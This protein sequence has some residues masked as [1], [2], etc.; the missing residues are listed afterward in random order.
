MHDCFVNLIGQNML[1]NWVLLTPS[2]R[3]ALYVV[4]LTYTQKRIHFLKTISV[5]MGNYMK[6]IKWACAVFDEFLVSNQ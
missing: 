6:G 1:T 4:V 3:N 2:Q 5:Y